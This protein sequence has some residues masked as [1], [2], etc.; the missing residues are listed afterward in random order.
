VKHADEHDEA[1]VA[2][3]VDQRLFRQT[4]RGLQIAAPN[5][6]HGET[7]KLRNRAHGMAVTFVSA[8]T[9]GFPRTASATGPASA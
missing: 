6:F 3:M 8:E 7:R 9:T 1:V 2:G 4:Q 5:L